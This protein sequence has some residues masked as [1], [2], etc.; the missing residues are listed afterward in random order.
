[1]GTQTNT[2]TSNQGQSGSVEGGSHP[3]SGVPSRSR[4]SCTRSSAPSADVAFDTVGNSSGVS[5]IVN[6]L[7]A[8]VSDEARDGASCRGS[9]SL[10]ARLLQM[11]SNASTASAWGHL[12][13]TA[14]AGGSCATT[15]GGGKFDANSTTAMTDP[16][17]PYTTTPPQRRRHRQHGNLSSDHPYSYFSE[18][19]GSAGRGFIPSTPVRPRTAAETSSDVAD[20]YTKASALKRLGIVGVSGTRARGL[21]GGRSSC[22]TGG[23]GSSRAV[24]RGGGQE[25]PGQDEYG[26]NMAI[27]NGGGGVGEIEPAPATTD[28]RDT[29]AVFGVVVRIVLHYFGLAITCNVGIV[30]PLVP[31]IVLKMSMRC[32]SKLPYAVCRWP[33]KANHR[34]LTKNPLPS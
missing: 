32:T 6:H 28:H 13:S 16:T 31:Y 22:T 7:H 23:S 20:H 34:P 25:H 8:G 18:P 29:D 19:S 14:S 3:D 26:G 12:A 15:Y 27:S 30:I 21:A 2:S 11:E 17:A 1:M 9:R 5:T 24:V 33:T 4:V 10:R